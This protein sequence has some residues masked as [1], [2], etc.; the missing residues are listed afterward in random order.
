MFAYAALHA[1]GGVSREG[2]GPPVIPE[3]PLRYPT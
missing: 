3:A 1:W 2:A